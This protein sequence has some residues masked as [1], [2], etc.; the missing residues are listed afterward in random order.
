MSG[1]ARFGVVLEKVDCGFVTK[2]VPLHNWILTRI[3]L[4][5]S[6]FERIGL[7][8]QLG[9]KSKVKFQPAMIWF[10]FLA[11]KVSVLDN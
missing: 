11:I 7:N 10:G 6:S 8:R 2:N 5:G 3:M 4:S 9:V 1:F